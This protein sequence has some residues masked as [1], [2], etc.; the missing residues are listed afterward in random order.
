MPQ[1]SAHLWKLLQPQIEW[2]S[3]EF[4][5]KGRKVNDYL[6]LSPPVFFVGDDFRSCERGAWCRL[7]TNGRPKKFIGDDD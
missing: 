4:L 2:G 3:W 7:S 1:Q 6:L 5:C